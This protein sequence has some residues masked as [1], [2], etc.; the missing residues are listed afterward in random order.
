MIGHRDEGVASGVFAEMAA[1]VGLLKNSGVTEAG[2]GEV[3]AGILQAQPDNDA[4]RL[5]VAQGCWAAGART[6]AVAHLRGVMARR[7]DDAPLR[8]A[9]VTAL[10]LTGGWAEG[11]ALAETAGGL[12]ENADL[13]RLRLNALWH[14]GR[15]EEAIALLRRMVAQAPDD[16][17]LHHELGQRL[18][19]T[20]DWMQGWPEF[21][22]RWRV[23]ERLEM[24]RR[25]ASPLERP[26]PQAWRG[27]SVLVFA[28]QGH[29]DTLMCLRYVPAV[30]ATGARVTLQIQP[31]LLRLARWMVGRMGA[32]IRVEAIGATVPACDFAVPMLHLPWAFGTL[33]G[34][35]PGTVPYLVAHPQ[36]VARW[37]ERVAALPGLR[38]G[39]T[40][41]G[42]SYANDAV[43]RAGDQIR[44]TT[45]A[46]LAPLG[47]V[48]GI[49]LVSLQVGERAAEAGAAPPGLVLQDW[50]GELRDFADTAAL[51]EALD[52]LI[53]VDTGVAHL[54]GALGRPVWL[55][56]R[57]DGCWRWLRDRDDSVWYPTVRQFRQA[58]PGNWTGV[59][60][61]VAE[62]LAETV[63]AWRAAGPPRR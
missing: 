56:N 32:D 43:G 6:E 12:A 15:T 39:L 11:L 25:P 58:T 23:A 44:S 9:L 62:A 40:W 19:A 46:A 28:E 47:G 54:A 26:D 13:Q 57:F 14:L 37:R 61:R 2:L 53:T 21:A 18:L 34:S 60:Q 30:V 48:A 22:W 45:L 63:A 50:T 27:R 31:G 24:W 35:V 42:A 17:S 29:G 5:A 20:G 7:A 33:P 41:A 51:V 59:A 52:L 55:L 4:A 1:L 3:L 36:A 38:V 16:S 10:L 49:S 8:Q